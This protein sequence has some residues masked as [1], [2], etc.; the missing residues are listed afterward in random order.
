MPFVHYGEGEDERMASK[1]RHE[2]KCVVL[3]L[4]EWYNFRVVYLFRREID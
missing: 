4:G 2:R 1:W 3:F